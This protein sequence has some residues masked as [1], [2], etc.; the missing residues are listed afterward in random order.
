M[1]RTKNTLSEKEKELVSLLI[2]TAKAQ[3]IFS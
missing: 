1:K 2:R 3:V